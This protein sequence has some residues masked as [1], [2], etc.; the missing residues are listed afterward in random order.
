MKKQYGV[1]GLI[2][3]KLDRKRNLTESEMN[4]KKV[5]QNLE[6]NEFQ[7]EERINYL[8]LFFVLI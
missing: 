3:K 5:V 7:D 6:M 1:I 2:K 8:I 4:L